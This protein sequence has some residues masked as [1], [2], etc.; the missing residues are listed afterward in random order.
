MKNQFWSVVSKASAVMTVTL[1]MALI[2]APGAWAAGKY[3]VLHEFTGGAD[4]GGPQDGLFIFDAAGNIYGTTAG[5]G[6]YGSGNVFT[7]TP[8][9]DGTWTENVLYSFGA[10]GGDPSSVRAGVIF[11]ASGNLYGTS[12]SGGDYGLGTVYELTPQSG[13]TWTES[14]LHS[15]T[16][17]SDGGYAVGGLIFDSSGNLYGTATI[18]GDD[19]GGVVFELSPNSDGTWTETVIHSFT[20]SDGGFPDHGSLIFDATGNLYGEASDLFWGPCCGTIFQLAPQSDGS[21]KETVLYHF[22]GGKD[23]GTPESTLIFDKAGS[24]YGATAEGGAYGAGVVFKLTP[25]AHSKWKERVLHQFKGGKDG[26]TPF[27]GVVFDTAGNAYGATLTGG[28]GPCGEWMGTG[29]GV[30]FKLIPTAHGQWTER[31]LRRLQGKPTGNPYGEVVLDGKG[32]SY[33]MASG[34]GTGGSGS[35][36]EIMP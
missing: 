10:N 1:I 32:N 7:L 9:S 16:G 31:V 13:G 12:W 19:G 6:T 30:V 8:N 14:V 17:G 4:G 26:A 29:C 34:D 11:D 27:A 28:G 3:K 35:V 24:L 33:G 18:G 5:G 25:G 2:L 21:W 36:F 23:G 20:G 22:T 15:F